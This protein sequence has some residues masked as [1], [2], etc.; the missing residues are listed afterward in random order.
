M[1]PC[2][3][4]TEAWKKQFAAPARAHVP[5]ACGF[6]GPGQG[7]A[8]A[9]G[10]ADIG[11][12]LPKGD[13]GPAYLQILM[14]LIRTEMELSWRRYHHDEMEKR[15]ERTARPGTKVESYLERF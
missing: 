9:G 12:F 3:L 4:F 10:E 1:T 7:G 15:G 8:D 11:N 13:E 2:E 6:Q 5:E 14:E